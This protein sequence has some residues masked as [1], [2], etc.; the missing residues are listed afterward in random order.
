[1]TWT[2]HLHGST[3]HL[4]ADEA[5]TARKSL[6]ARARGLFG[7]LVPGG[8]Q[9]VGGT[10]VTEGSP[11]VDLAE[12]PQPEDTDED[13]DEDVVAPEPAPEPA[14]A[15]ESAASTAPAEVSPAAT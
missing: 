8:H 5:E 11:P 10:L 7:E 4:P 1:M 14:P 6:L 2:L 9:G 13:H 3:D 15:P 12:P